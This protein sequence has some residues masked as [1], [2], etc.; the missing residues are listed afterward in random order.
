MKVMK[1]VLKRVCV[2]TLAMAV[3]LGITPFYTTPVSKADGSVTYLKKSWND[4]DFAVT[5]TTETCSEYNS[6]TTISE[7][8]PVTWNAGTYVVSTD[9]IINSRITVTGTVNLILCDDAVLNANK[10]ITVS[11]GNTLNI[12]AQSEDTNMGKLI[13]KT[14]T[15]DHYAA[16][17][18]DN[19]NM[20]CGTVVINGVT[21]EAE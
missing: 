14:M 9:A 15:A 8:N 10:G 16:I 19:A 3:M 11:S 2:F 1:N 21:L 17:G 5:C 7:T 12:Y 13:A 18:G 4:T 6:V 20:N